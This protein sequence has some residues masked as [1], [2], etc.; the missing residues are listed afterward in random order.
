MSPA[1]MTIKMWHYFCWTK[2][3]VRMQPP[4]MVIINLC[5]VFFCWNSE[6]VLIKYF[7]FISI[8][9]TPLHIAARKNQMDIATTLLEF[10]AQ[11]DSESRA[12]FTPLH[13]ASQEGHVEMSNLLLEHKANP[14]HQAKN[15]LTPM[16]L[17]AQEDRSNVAQ[18]LV[19]HGANVNTKTKQ[20]YTP[21]HMAAHF[22]QLNMVRFL[23]QN[24]AN[25]N[26]DTALG[27]TPLHQSAQQGH[28]HI[29]NVLLEHKADPDAVTSV[30][31]IH[32][33]YN[34]KF[35]NKLNDEVPCIDD[36][37][38]F[39]FWINSKDKHRCS[40]RKN[41]DTLVLLSHWKM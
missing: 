38:L 19:D 31:W 11:A 36:L 25:V 39:S 29:V 10:G 18:I 27:Y 14:N 33:T 35:F 28:L 15:G 12:G 40:F 26:S 41:W 23:L 8:G 37:F 5:S 20:N 21:L 1:T 4:K 3:Q 32:S 17:C 9:H 30:S 16:H 34:F 13:L 7:I 6:T 22:G 24:G 2:G